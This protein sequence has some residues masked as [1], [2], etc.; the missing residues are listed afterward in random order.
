[1]AVL[2]IVRTRKNMEDKNSTLY[3]KSIINAAKEMEVEVDIRVANNIDEFKSIVNRPI[4][5]LVL[6]PCEYHY[7][8]K[9]NAEMNQTARVCARFIKENVSTEKPVLIISRSR[10]I[11]RPLANILLDYNYTV[12]I[13]H[14]RTENLKDLTLDYDTI[15]IAAGNPSVADNIC[16]TRGFIV[17]VADDLAGGAHDQFC[18]QRIG[19]REIGKATTKMLLEDC[20]ELANQI[21]P[22]ECV[23]V[24]PAPYGEFLK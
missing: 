22:E 16:L 19:M 12:T 15:V 6:Q 18:E 23:D 1:M 2:Q 11:G 17:D 9:Y 21:R 5:T 20:V 13:A 8:P 3:M 14:S 7:E 24:L 4:P 10:L